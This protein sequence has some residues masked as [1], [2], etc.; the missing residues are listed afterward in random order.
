MHKNT[1]KFFRMYITRQQAFQM[2]SLTDMQLAGEDSSPA[3]QT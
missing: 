3:R 2:E 1:R